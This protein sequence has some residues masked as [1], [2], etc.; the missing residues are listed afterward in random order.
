MK[1]PAA[2]LFSSDLISPSQ[3]KLGIPTL[4]GAQFLDTARRHWKTC[5]FNY[6]SSVLKDAESTIMD[7]Q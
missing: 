7:A 4:K 1:A 3:E 6:G 2:A 5:S